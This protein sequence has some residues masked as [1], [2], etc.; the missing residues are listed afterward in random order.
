LRLAVIGNP[1]AGNMW[2]RRLLV[3][4]YGLEERSAH[5]PAEVDW[6]GLPERCV[7]QLHWYR[8]RELRRLLGRSGFQVLVPVRGPLDA[9]LSILQFAPHEPET[10]R[11]LD[12]LHGDER[13]IVG[14]T[15]TSDAF[16]RYATGPRAKALLDVSPRWWDHAV[17]AVRY[18]DLVADPVARLTEL[19]AAIGSA[20]AKTPSEAVEAASFERLAAEARNNHFWRGRP[21]QWR[22][23]LPAQV[24]E[25]IIGAHR[26]FMRRFDLTADPDPALTMQEA[27]ARWEALVG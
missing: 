7:L 22:E 12:G 17:Y 2:L 21:G 18:V 19:A 8:T 23:L 9:L 16:V 1:R 15:P 6:D 26:D 4:L 10:A 24:V 11:W 25:P 14:A 3:A 27:L 5:T 13:S 20:T